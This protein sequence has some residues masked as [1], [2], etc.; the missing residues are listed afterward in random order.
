MSS[1]AEINDEIVEEMKRLIMKVSNSIK[2]R[3]ITRGV[4]EIPATCLL[5]FL[6]SALSSGLKH[7]EVIMVL[8]NILGRE[9]D[10]MVVAIFTFGLFFGSIMGSAEFDEY[11]SE[12]IKL[13][14][15]IV[16]AVSSHE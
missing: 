3:E 13:N 16:S 11:V 7:P 10:V 2:E 4:D 9:L 14:D 6:E 5:A 12:F 1:E 15:K 8:K